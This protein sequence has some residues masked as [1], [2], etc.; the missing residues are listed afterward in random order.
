MQ[1][2]TMQQ[3]FVREL[4][5][6]SPRSICSFGVDEPSLATTAIQYFVMDLQCRRKKG[7]LKRKLIVTLPIEISTPN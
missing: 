7:F 5:E 1:C 2:I 4:G 6:I 3:E